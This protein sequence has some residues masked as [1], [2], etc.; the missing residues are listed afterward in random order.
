MQYRD[1]HIQGEKELTQPLLEEN[2]EPSGGRGRGRCGILS[3]T[4]RRNRNQNLGEVEVEQ[5]RRSEVGRG[6]GRGGN[7]TSGDS[8]DIGVA[9]PGKMA[10]KKRG[11]SEYRRMTKKDAKVM[12]E[13]L[14][15]MGRQKWRLLLASLAMAVAS[16]AQLLVPKV[17]GDIIDNLSGDKDLRCFNVSVLVLLFSVALRSMAAG[18]RRF[19]FITAGEQLVNSLK[20]D[21]FE[22]ILV[23]EVAFF[24]EEETGE[25]I[26]RITDDTTKLR[27]TMSN[28]F[29]SFLK[30]L[31]S[32]SDITV[33]QN[34]RSSVSRGG[35]CNISR[36]KHSRRC[37]FLSGDCV[38]PSASCTPRFR[39]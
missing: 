34:M 39:A 19:Y 24:D 8:G 33:L 4:S 13:I 15:Y 14:S 11:R 28:S 32:G 16:A 17:L 37:S 18:V 5:V 25:L 2:A 12:R 36:A 7:V 6:N 22:S 31:G 9:G 21:L 1:R 3:H 20:R 23:R 35:D 30:V 27:S 26:N 38:D 10:G 29:P